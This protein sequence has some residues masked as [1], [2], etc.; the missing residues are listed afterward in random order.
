M[1]QI[2]FG[3]FIE[4]NLPK[5]KMPI[6]DASNSR[7][8]ISVYVVHEVQKN[9]ISYLKKNSKNESGGLLIGHPFVDM[10]NSNKKFVFVTGHFPTK[11]A[12][13]GPAHFS[14]SPEELIRG[15]S[16]IENKFPGLVVVGW[17]HSHPGHGV[18]LSRQD[19]NIVENIY[20]SDWHLAYV[21]DTLKD[22]DGFFVG[23]KA[24][25]IENYNVVDNVPDC[26]IAI[27]KYNQALASEGNG[28]ANAIFEFRDWF[29][30]TMSYSLKHWLDLGRYQNLDLFGDTKKKRKLFSLL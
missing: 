20:N 15:R 24:I 16:E 19:M 6:S 21:V 3:E 12:D 27:Q 7:D 11:S 4:F 26:V 5:E 30:S 1:S 17:Y 28:D 23:S 2:E 29:V 8:G 18:F 22:R 13:F 14:V 10:N 25:S 9:I